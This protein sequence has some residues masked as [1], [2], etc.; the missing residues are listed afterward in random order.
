MSTE[1]ILQKNKRSGYN[2]F[3]RYSL[4]PYNIISYLM[5]NNQMIWK[6]LKWTSS[7]AWSR[8]DLSVEE[9]SLLIYSGQEDS[10]NYNVFMD[11]GQP[12]AFTREICMLRISNWHIT[13]KNRTVGIVTVSF[14]I[15]SHYKINHLTNYTTRNDV[16]VEEILST[17]NGVEL[18]N[19][20]GAFYFDGKRELTDRM[21]NTGQ[22]PF[23]GKQVFMSMNYG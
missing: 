6:L 8:S 14:Q 12:D 16:I 10:S 7:D 21:I 4:I 5:E 3:K 20:L 13:P 1:T 9:K 19:G 2:L 18:E 23:A 22:I 11:V 15:Y 17:L